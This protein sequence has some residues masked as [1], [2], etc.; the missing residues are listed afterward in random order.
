MRTRYNMAWSFPR[1]KQRKIA[2]HQGELQSCKLDCVS[3][4][5]I[6]YQGFN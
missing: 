5:G 1:R 4:N 2:F 3:V 6:K